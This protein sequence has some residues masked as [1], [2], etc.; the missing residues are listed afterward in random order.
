MTNRIGFSRAELGPLVVA[1]GLT[2]GMAVA[3]QERPDEAAMFG[4]APDAGAPSGSAAVGSPSPDAGVATGRDED[5]IFGAGPSEVSP[6]ETG[7]A[8]TPVQNVGPPTDEPTRDRQVLEG[9]Q[10]T[11]AF[12]SNEAADDPL[13]IGGL[14]YFRT[15]VSYA[16]NEQFKNV[17]FSSPTLV[18]AYFDGR[19]TDRIRAFV[20][21]RLTYDPSIDTA[22]ATVQNALDPEGGV[23]QAGQSLFGGQEVENPR[24][25]L[26]QVWLRFDIARQVFLT[27]GKQ[28]VKWGT[29]RFWNPTDFLSPQRR[30]PLQVFDVRTGASMVKV[31]VPWEERGW[32]FYA[33]AL[34]DNVGP[35]DV[36]GELGFASRAEILLGNTEIGADA[37]FRLGR[38]PRFGFDVSTPLGPF[39]AYGEI[40]LRG[41]PDSPLWRRRAGADDDAVRPQD[42]ERYLPEGPS[43]QASGGLT[44][45]WAYNENDTVTVGAEYFYNSLGT[46]DARIYPWLIFNGEFTPFYLGRHYAGAYAVLAAPGSWENTTF[47][48]SALGNL[49]DRSFVSRLD[50]TQRVLSYLSVEAFV[51][52][53]FGND[54]GEFRFGVDLPPTNINGFPI[55]AIFIPAPVFELGAALRVSI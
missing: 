52:G 32:N 31:H 36:L 10:I 17:G 34:L 5:A 48:L 49:S 45:T 1:L 51:S 33:I 27:V 43:P 11:D 30:N 47:V 18:D 7:A 3:A 41:Q 39:D 2:A 42:F 15:I 19:P 9:P 24:V 25:L 29:S 14:F 26:D 35:S 50:V 55:P 8:G 6:D 12:E 28:H 21:G 46:D 16:E 54:R 40:A 38:K 4:E 37:V 23:S 20:S 44:Y 53:H 22:N 13:R